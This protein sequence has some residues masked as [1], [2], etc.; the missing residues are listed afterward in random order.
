MSSKAYLATTKELD[1]A[2]AVVA[3]KQEHHKNDSDS[4]G[5]K[6]KI[7]MPYGYICCAFPSRA[8]ER[9]QFPFEG[10]IPISVR[11]HSTGITALKSSELYDWL[12]SV[13]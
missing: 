12:L 7:A 6:K 10:T 8:L 13:V 11:G 9:L 5:Y 3:L 1:N 2:A 4:D